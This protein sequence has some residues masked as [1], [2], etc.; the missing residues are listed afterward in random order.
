M[1]RFNLILAGGLAAVL[2]TG[3]A[4]GGGHGSVEDVVKAR[5]ELMKAVGKNFGVLGDM[6]KGKLDYDATAAVAAAK[7]LNE[8]ASTDPATLWIEGSSNADFTETRVKPELLAEIDKVSEIHAAW[9]TA[10]TA[11]ETAA[12]EGL[13]ALRAA[14]G[15]IGEQC[16]ACHKPYRAPKS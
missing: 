15:P 13:D 9:S 14:M 8:A 2:A 5:Q 11:M 10:T 6:A 1:K 7:A 16:G 4:I 12:G 3:A